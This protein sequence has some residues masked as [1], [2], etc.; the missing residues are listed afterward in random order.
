[1]LPALPSVPGPGQTGQKVQLTSDVPGVKE[2]TVSPLERSLQSFSTCTEVLRSGKSIHG[3]ARV[4]LVSRD[5][6]L[7][8]ASLVEQS[9]DAVLLP[10]L[11]SVPSNRLLQQQL[12]WSVKNLT[13]HP[14]LQHFVAD[15]HLS[16]ICSL[17]VSWRGVWAA[18]AVLGMGLPYACC[19][20]QGQDQQLSGCP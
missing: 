2:A 18:R 7:S 19:R 9:S 6:N 12:C 3:P 5:L 10:A 4:H 8:E 1:M 16:C 11:N 13:L 15:K 14:L 17:V 20:K